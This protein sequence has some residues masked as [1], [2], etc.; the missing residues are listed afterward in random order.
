MSGRAVSSDAIVGFIERGH[1][2]AF[3]L[4]FVGGGVEFSEVRV[5]GEMFDLLLSQVF[6]VIWLERHAI[7]T[8]ALGTM[9]THLHIAGP[10]DL[11]VLLVQR[12]IER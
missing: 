8:H 12:I 1:E 5:E 2:R 3:E 6:G 11:A 4:R 9:S 7:V 10:M